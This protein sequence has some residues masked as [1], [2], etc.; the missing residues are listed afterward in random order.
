M[1]VSSG[2]T[3][4]RS[5]KISEEGMSERQKACL[6]QIRNDIE[7]GGSLSRALSQFI[8]L[9][10]SATGLIG[11]GELSG[12]L[13]KALDTAKSLLEREDELLKKC[14]SA[15]AYPVIIGMFASLLTFGLV[16]GVMP[17]IIPML[18]GL[19]VQLPFMTV[20]VIFLSESLLKYGLYAFGG[21]IVFIVV[22]KM[23]NKRWNTFKRVNHL[24][25]MNTP[26]IGHLLF[27]YSLTVFLRSCGA[28]VESGLP[29]AEAYSKS[30]E[31][32]TLI[33]FRDKLNSYSS[34]IARGIPI[35][36]LLNFKRIPKYVSSLLNAG[37]A[38]G[39]LGISI[40]RSANILDR[41]IEHA[42]KRLTSLIEPVMM[43]AMGGGVG[44]IAV[45]IMMPIYD[46]SKVLQH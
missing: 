24:V 38:T 45:S 27:L 32:V 25:L 14:A 9:P 15:M 5:L 22:W 8:G 11:Q 20:A 26:I 33:P 34:A 28:L 35:G 30:I 6:V 19:H 31:S 21:L 39:T 18:K 36:N 41:D 7:S 4:D 12:G 37:E 42:L 16:R 13:V 10:I 17:Q 29:T 44:V 23:L 2:M 1:Y 46:I 40:S 3:I 43:V